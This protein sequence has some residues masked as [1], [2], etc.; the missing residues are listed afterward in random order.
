MVI[1]SAAL[2]GIPEETVE[3][4]IVDGANPFQIFFK[5]KVPQIKGTIIVVWTT[6]TGVWAVQG[7]WS[8]CFW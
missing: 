6:M 4:A 1:L 5:I 3:A 7:P 8:S 2:R